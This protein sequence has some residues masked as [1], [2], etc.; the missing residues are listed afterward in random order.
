MKNLS[1]EYQ[2]VKHN[3]KS[4]KTSRSNAGTACSVSASDGT[5]AGKENDRNAMIKVKAK[6][7]ARGK[8]VAKSPPNK[9]QLNISRPDNEAPD[10]RGERGLGLSPAT[11][12][13]ANKENDDSK[14]LPTKEQ[15]LELLGLVRP[16]D[17]RSEFG[18]SSSIQTHLIESIK[19]CG[20]KSR[21]E[22]SIIDMITT[23]CNH[24]SNREKEINTWTQFSDV[25]AMTAAC[26]LRESLTNFQQACASRDNARES[27]KACKMALHRIRGEIASMKE[28]LVALLSSFP[29][30]IE[31]IRVQLELKLG[32]HIDYLYS[33]SKTE[34]SDAIEE[35]MRAHDN[36][37]QKLET[38]IASLLSQ[39]SSEETKLQALE[40][41]LSSCKNE[42]WAEKT[43]CSQ[44]REELCDAK[45]TII[46]FEECLENERRN[47][48]NEIAQI[49]EKMNKDLDD[50]EKRVKESL[51]SLTERK[52]AEIAVALNRAKNAEN[53]LEELRANFLGP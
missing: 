42:L 21:R 25:I 50:V 18:L 20:L 19:L 51:K 40:I 14:Q 8:V 37:K 48:Q 36:E 49:N 26:K 29:P 30:L 12:A 34:V 31:E 6:S 23:L 43:R 7:L 22:T 2:Q 44:L 15:G 45:N 24:L 16:S 38:T 13:S 46:H 41:Q 52:D 10:E 53:V 3:Y 28:D 1:L 39:Q 27:V 32:S 17:S 35:L 33:E 9:V 11:A 47:K 5:D 4:M